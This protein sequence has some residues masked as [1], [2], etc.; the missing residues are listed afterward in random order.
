[1]SLVSTASKRIG[2]D[3]PR[4]YL[5]IYRHLQ[6]DRAFKVLNLHAIGI[7]THFIQKHSGWSVEYR[8]AISDKGIYVNRA[9]TLSLH[10]VYIVY[11]LQGEPPKT[12][13]LNIYFSHNF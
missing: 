11:I 1:M 2:Y 6:K 4:V 12:A 5:Q 3:F 13:R 7:Q 8:E 10:I 9:I